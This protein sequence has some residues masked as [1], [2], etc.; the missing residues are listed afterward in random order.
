MIESQQSLVL[1][2]WS[3]F[4]KYSQKWQPNSGWGHNILSGLRTSSMLCPCIW[5]RWEWGKGKVGPEFWRGWYSECNKYKY[6]WNWGWDK[7]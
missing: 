1:M 2:L 6:G 4:D 3:I 5:C 7:C